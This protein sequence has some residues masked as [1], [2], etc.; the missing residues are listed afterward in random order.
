MMA[1][2]R[3]Y[4]ANDPE[5]TRRGAQNQG[6]YD[7]PIKGNVKTWTPPEGRSRIRIL[8]RTWEDEGGKWPRHWSIEVFIHYQIGADNAA[9]MCLDKMGKG[10]CPICEERARLALEGDEEGAKE[11]RW[12]K[13]RLVWIL[14]RKNPDDQAMVWKMPVRSI[15]S[16]ICDRSN[17]PETGKLLPID[18]PEEG[19][20]ITFRRQGKQMM[21]T[22]YSS[23][24]IARTPSSIS[25]DDNEYNSILDFIE[26][27]PLPDQLV[28]Y[29]YDY[30]SKVFSGRVS[31]RDKDE[32]S[33]P[34]PR[35]RRNRRASAEE[36]EEP[37]EAD[38]VEDEV[39]DTPPPRS[40]RK[41]RE[42]K[43]SAKDI[44]A[45]AVDSLLDE[46]DEPEDN[47]EDEPKKD[48]KDEVSSGL[49]RRR[50][51]KA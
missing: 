27:N 23:V 16:E 17:D 6:D 29:D 12:T 11:L 24:E 33:A 50:R 26:A 32:D 34:P 37:E 51:Q 45:K 3:G 31:S 5:E 30:I 25:D 15:Y 8:P 35:S 20:D 22:N 13:S 46:I 48:L 7:K 44:Q 28:F 39:D 40:R 9:Y 2:Y 1:K 18:E 43:P 14:D 36:G 21:N 38:D 10:P 41:V 19:Y 42:E 47:E 4:R 49:R